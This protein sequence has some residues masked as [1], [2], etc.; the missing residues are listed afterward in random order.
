MNHIETITISSLLK[1]V[2][3]LEAQR[4]RLE[5][6]DDLLTKDYHLSK[7]VSS[8]LCDLWANWPF[9]PKG[10]LAMLLYEIDLRGLR[11]SPSAEWA[12]LQS[13][14]TQ[15]DSARYFLP[16]KVCSDEALYYPNAQKPQI[17]DI[18]LDTLCNNLKQLCETHSDDV[19][20]LSTAL[21]DYMEDYGSFLSPDNGAHSLFELSKLRAGGAAC[22]YFQMQELQRAPAGDFLD[23]P[24]ILV[25]SID[26]LGIKDFKFQS[27]YADELSSITAAS[28]YIDL[29]RETVLD[30]FLDS[31]D[32]FRCNLI[33]SGGRHLH[34]FLPNT[35]RIRERLKQ[36]IHDTNDWLS[37]QFGLQLYVSYGTCVIEG[38][39]KLKTF[40]EQN[41]LG[42]FTKI[43]NQKA[44]MESHKYSPENLAQIGRS[45]IK[46]EDLTHR[47]WIEAVANNLSEEKIIAV[48]DIPGDGVPIGHHRF[49]SEWHGETAGVIRL[50]N[51]K[52]SCWQI[53]HKV[54]QIGIWHQSVSAPSFHFVP[55]IEKSFG[56]FRMDIDNFRSNMLNRKQNDLR[57]SP[58]DKM[59]YS[60]QLA[61]FLR[62][63]IPRLL[64]TYLST[65]ESGQHV[66]LSVI[67]EGADDM[68]I[69]GEMEHLL[70][71]TL[72]MYLHYRKFTCNFGSFSAGVCF[73]D[74]HKTLQQ[75]ARTA[76]QLLDFAKTVPGKNTVV[77]KDN[78]GVHSWKEIVRYGTSCQD[79]FV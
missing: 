45:L 41:Y 18:Y 50:Y 37:R 39:M 58:V 77:I 22:A 33:F 21:F 2:V 59:E 6:I 60:R 31:V 70:R 29:F 1:D 79:T 57:V 74:F 65:Q 30:D 62:R 23:Q 35:A 46:S 16:G 54:R 15:G 34:L 28:F 24:M 52:G 72:Q 19:D 7:D 49:A 3:F 10:D 40:K 73:Y 25:C 13:V 51:K 47:A 71:F 56:L 63:D 27:S 68:F 48:R 12:P 61:Y 8:V 42:I 55:N 66:I 4:R 64:N 76:Q 20:I 78:T 14:F 32:L 67:H 38:L 44:I 5:N 69:F 26:F 11:L 9:P 43:A 53:N 36:S 75:N 17:S